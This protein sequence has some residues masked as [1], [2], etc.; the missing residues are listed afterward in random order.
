[1]QMMAHGAQVWS[2]HWMRLGTFSL[3][4]FLLGF[5]Q[6]MAGNAFGQFRLGLDFESG[7]G[8]LV[9]EYLT[10]M[11][12]LV[13]H[14]ALVDISIAPG[15]APPT[16]GAFDAERDA[17]QLVVGLFHFLESARTARRIKA[18]PRNPNAK[19]QPRARPVRMKPAAKRKHPT[20]SP[21]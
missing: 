2:L 14:P 12:T 3:I 1:M 4:G 18:M 16:M 19:R 7:E 21:S 10:A 9:E 15:I 8:D 20:S 17:R 5:G 6:R 13:R 11:A